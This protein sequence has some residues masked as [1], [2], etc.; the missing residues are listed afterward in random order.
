MK[1]WIREGAQRPEQ[2]ASVGPVGVQLAGQIASGKGSTHLAQ[3]KFRAETPRLI[4][5][6][7]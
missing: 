3:T 7:T 6:L 5:L 1:V 4:L 2:W